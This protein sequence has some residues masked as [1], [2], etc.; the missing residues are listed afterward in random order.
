MVKSCGFAIGNLRVKETSLLNKSD[1]A[2]L[3]NAKTVEELAVLMGEKSAGGSVEK[4]SVPE[5]LSAKQEKLWEYIY[6]IAPDMALFEPFLYENDF[7]NLKA[8]LKAVVSDKDFEKLLAKPFTV[9]PE[10]IKT[11]VAEKKFDILPE[12]LRNTAIKAYDILTKSGDTQTCDCVIDA[13]CINARIEKATETGNKT[14]M[15]LISIDAF[16]K[17]I[18]VALRSAKAGKTPAFLD[19]VLSKNGIADVSELKAAAILG[20]EKVLELL[21]SKTSVGGNEAAELFKISASQFERFA[22]NTV[23]SVAKKCKSVTIG[24]EPLIGYTVAVLNEIKN[25]RI[26]YSGIKT[27]QSSEQIEERLRDVYG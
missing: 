22:D 23:L 14:V 19:E 20:E 21:A 4:M 18:K 1:Y 7:H 24:I 8:I 11:A 25:L 27:G 16:Y 5:I 12:L 9:T 26:I 2:A 13:A 6:D 10:L 17:N 15:E 3:M